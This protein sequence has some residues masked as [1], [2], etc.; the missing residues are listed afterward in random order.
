LISTN[1]A[2]TT[3][4]GI[5]AGRFKRR[6]GSID[7][8]DSFFHLR[9]DDQR[10]MF[11]RFAAHA[12]PGAPLMFTSGPAQGEAIGSFAGEPLYHASLDPAEYERLLVANG[13]AMRAYLEN[14]PDCGE[15]TVWLA[16]YRG[17]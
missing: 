10:A 12:A 14:D 4:T 6:R 9:M 17:Q 15:H 2:L 5:A 8:C 3:S 1:D 11:P 7:S 16:Q 13:F